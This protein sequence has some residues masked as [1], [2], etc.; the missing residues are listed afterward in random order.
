MP[1]PAIRL[2]RAFLIAVR[3]GTPG[4][5]PQR[6]HR[7]T[8]VFL[9]FP[10]YFFEVALQKFIAETLFFC[11]FLYCGPAAARL[12]FAGRLWYTVFNL[13]AGPCEHS[14][15]FTAARGHFFKL[16]SSAVQQARCTRPVP[17]SLFREGNA[18][19]Q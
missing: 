9:R 11:F 17:V 5:P 10:P 13:S 19:W 7:N 4:T 1:A 12:A 18:K 8:I 15:F 6:I 2:G 14:Q 3:A 16:I